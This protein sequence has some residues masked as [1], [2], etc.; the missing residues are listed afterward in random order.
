MGL[1]PEDYDSNEQH[2]QVNEWL[3]QGGFGPKQEQ[4][5]NQGGPNTVYAAEQDLAEALTRG[6]IT[7][8]EAK[9]RLNALHEAAREINAE[10]QDGSNPL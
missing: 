7:P 5:L 10:L 6:I 9:L 1:R 2:A 3:R 8:E 4:A